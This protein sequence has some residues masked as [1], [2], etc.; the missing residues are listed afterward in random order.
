MNIA[1]VI[2]GDG[3]GITKSEEVYLGVHENGLNDALTAL[4]NE[5]RLYFDVGSTSPT[6]QGH[7]YFPPIMIGSFPIGWRIQFSAPKIDL[8]PK[9][10]VQNPVALAPGQ[11]SIETIVTI[12]LLNIPIPI[13]I[14]LVGHLVQLP[15]ASNPM[16]GLAVDQIATI[17]ALPPIVQSTLLAIINFLA[18]NWKLP[19]ATFA[20]GPLHIT[21]GPVVDLNIAALYGQL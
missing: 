13:P 12:T 2:R 17:P 7:T 21:Q 1:L 18:V 10:S 19:L 15:P 3:M 20:F 4:Y 8:Y 6:T 5:R 11:F 16:I 9:T 14:V